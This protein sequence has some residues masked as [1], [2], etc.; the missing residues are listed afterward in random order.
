M[1]KIV[2]IFAIFI[3]LPVYWNTDWEKIEEFKRTNLIPFIER[4]IFDELKDI[5]LSV[6]RLK[7]E[8]TE[9]ITNKELKLASEAMNY[10]V[11]TTTYFFYIITWVW[12]LLSIIWWTSIKELK[13]SVKNLADKEVNKLAKK[14]EK[15]LTDIEDD[16]RWKTQK[17]LLNQQEIEKTQQI[18]YLWWQAENERD[19]QSKLN[20]YNQILTIDPQAWDSYLKKAEINLQ[21]WN[22][23]ESV[24]N[25]SQAINI[26]WDSSTAYYYRAWAFIQMWKKDE[27][28]D[29]LKSAIQLSD[30]LI[31][32]IKNDKVF[33]ELK[34][35][36]EFKKIIS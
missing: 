33:D 21:I 29:D 8:M 35:N 32:T 34:K 31:D 18:S 25:A 24:N 9:K 23:Q 3:A 1:K 14:Y 11:N 36:K 7:V 19:N 10:S 12:V 2:L 13:W 16:L 30:N 4:Y 26:L 17:I 28:L 5:R 27:A 6:E 22:F 15:R 20:I